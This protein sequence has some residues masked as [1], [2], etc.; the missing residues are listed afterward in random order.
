[1]K[2]EKKRGEK[3][4]RLKATFRVLQRMTWVFL[5]LLIVTLALYLGNRGYRR[6]QTSPFSQLKTVAIS[7]N[8]YL[9]KTDLTYYLR[10]NEKSNLL[11]LDIKSL[12]HKLVSH[13]WI[14]NANIHRRLPYTLTINIQERLPVALIKIDRLYY[15]DRD[16]AVFDK[17]NK[18]IGCDYPVFTGPRRFSE[19]RA[20]S[21]LITEALPLITK[22]TSPIISE[23]HLDL[24]RGITMITVAD[25]L[26][27]KLGL[28]DLSHRFHRF[29]STYHYLRRREVIMKYIDCRYPDRVVVKYAKTPSRHQAPEEKRE[30]VG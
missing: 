4:S 29:L 3:R 14:K 27:V 23:I 24:S 21:P 20:Y 18:E 22:E 7:G 8:H 19:I 9:T 12:Y 1:M 16:G 26:L 5:C 11:T 15:V 25:A 17:I 13:P 6:L 28:K 2:K 10:I 30:K